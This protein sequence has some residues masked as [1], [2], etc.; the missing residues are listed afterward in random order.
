MQAFIIRRLIQAIFVIF[1]VVTLV[2]FLIRVSGDPASLGV[3]LD[4][5]RDRAEIEAEY[6]EI[7]QKMGLDKPLYVQYLVFW[8]RTLQLD[9]GYSFRYGVPVTTVVFERLPNSLRLGAAAAVLGILVGLPLGIIAALKRG[10]IIDTAATTGAVLGIV[11]PQFFLAIILIMIFSVSLR[12]LPTSGTGTWRHLILPA[13]TL[14]TGLMATVAR[15]GRSG[16]LEAMNQDYI[17]TARAKGLA[18]RGVIFGHA[19]RN[20]SMSIITVTLSA[21]PHLIGTVVIVEVVFAWPGVGNLL[22]QAVMARDYPVVFLD[23][24][25]FS[26]LTV[27][28][29]LLL[30][31]AYMVVDP[32]IRHR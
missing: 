23:V 5:N 19:L 26:I 7:R 18:E 14:S 24:I 16:M 4:P 2:F 21:L 8:Q 17:R 32:R 31:L 27:F 15:I 12:W 10:T 9:F 3:N 11:I 20:G 29:F 22:A 30:D 1:L 6:Q 25:L 13:V 28:T